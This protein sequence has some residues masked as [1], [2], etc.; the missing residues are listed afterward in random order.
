MDFSRCTNFVFDDVNYQIAYQQLA[1][2]KFRLWKY[3]INS[4]KHIYQSD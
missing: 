4:G 2:K 3:G 1:K